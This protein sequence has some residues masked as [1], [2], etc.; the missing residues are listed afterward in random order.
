M[1]RPTQ[2]I[3]EN[4]QWRVKRLRFRKKRAVIWALYQLSQPARAVLSLPLQRSRRASGG[5]LG[6]DPLRKGN[7]PNT[8]RLQ[9]RGSDE[10]ALL[11]LHRAS[12]LIQERASEVILRVFLHH[13]LDG[14][15]AATRYLAL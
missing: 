4:F 7:E 11:V 15:D 3:I 8:L 14:N 1:L 10:P 2:V 13:H 5:L 6:I 9:L 12:D